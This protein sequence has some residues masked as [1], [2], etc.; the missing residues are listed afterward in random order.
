MVLTY[1]TLAM[2][3]IHLVGTVLSF[4][5]RTFP[6]LIGY[7][8]AIYE[9]VYYFLLVASPTLYVNYLLTVVSYLYLFIHVVGGTAYLRGLLGALYSPA[10]LKYYGAYEFVEMLYLISVL[11]SI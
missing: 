10:R 5:G 2:I 1:L 4:S 11:F 6:K 7:P 8:I 3:L 9:M